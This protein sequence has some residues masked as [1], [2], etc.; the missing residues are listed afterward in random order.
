MIFPQDAGATRGRRHVKTLNATEERAGPDAARPRREWTS[1]SSERA[2]RSMAKAVSWRFVGTLDTFILSYLLISFLGPLI[3]M[4]ETGSHASNLKTAGYIAA[5]EV[6][7]K[8]LLYYFHERAWARVAWNMIDV[9]GRRRREG[10]RRSVAKTAS[11]RIL[12]SLDTTLLAFI[13]TGHIGTAL[14]IGGLEVVTKLL[15]YYFHER[16]WS[17]VGLGRH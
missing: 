1:P 7:T 3:G 8:I 15:L 9:P 5:T 2:W 10:R 17:R 11:W 6:V 4:E 14:S 16:A 12:A 13:F